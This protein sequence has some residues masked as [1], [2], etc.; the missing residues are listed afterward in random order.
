MFPFF[1]LNDMIKYSTTY[2]L[3]ILVLMSCSGIDSIY[4]ID[5]PLS[6]KTINSQTEYFSLNIPDGW[7]KVDANGDAYVDIWLVN[8]TDEFS[9]S[10]MPIKADVIFPANSERETENFETLIKIYI[11]SLLGNKVDKKTVEQFE[12]QSINFNALE[13]KTKS[14]RERFVFFRI[15]NKY[16]V[17]RAVANSRNINYEK[18]FRIQNSVLS[19]VQSIKQ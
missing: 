17:S 6:N 7:R 3:L 15:N 11:E 13:M 4:K 1:I 10:F 19:S 16:F 2:I 18:L 9:I 14:N 8:D 12:I 5:F